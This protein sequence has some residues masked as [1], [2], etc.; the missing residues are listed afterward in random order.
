M[1][2]LKTGMTGIAELVVGTNDTAPKVGSGHIAVL[3]TPVMINLAEES[4]LDAIEA[5]LS[6]GKQSLG[7]LVNIS[8]IAATPIGMKVLAEAKL[9]KI[10][11][12]LLEF[13]ILVRDEH[14]IIGKGQH[15]R[16]VVTADRF[17]KRV[18]EKANR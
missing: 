16:V 17:Q 8:H 6:A 4:A 9:T 12:R 2:R 18:D 13:S 3:A 10:D 1:D 14:E 11:G 7:T 15:M 5:H